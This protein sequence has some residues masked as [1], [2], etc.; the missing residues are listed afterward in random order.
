ML[1]VSLP[2]TITGHVFFHV[3]TE[4]HLG[5]TRQVIAQLIDN[6]PDNPIKTHGQ[7][8]ENEPGSAQAIVG[9]STITP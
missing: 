9:H 2:K 1:A 5:P 8:G 4:I 7:Q 3:L 6:A